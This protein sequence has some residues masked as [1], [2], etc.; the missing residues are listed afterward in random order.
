MSNTLTWNQ[1]PPKEELIQ[2]E[3]T[4]HSG[5]EV[6]TIFPEL[7]GMGGESQV[8]R[9]ERQSDH[10]SLAAK[11]TP[12]PAIPDA[13]RRK[14]H[15]EIIDTLMNG[16]AAAHHLMPVFAR[17]R[18]TLSGVR[19]EIQLLP[20]AE[21]LVPK[22]TEGKMPPKCDY[23]TLR[24]RVI[25]SL[26]DA[27]HFLHERRYVHR[28]IK[29][30]NIYRLG[31]R[32]VLGDFGTVTKINQ[33]NEITNVTVYVRGTPGFMAP[34]LYA[35][36]FDEA[37]DYYALGATIGALYTGKKHVYKGADAGTIN[38]L[39]KKKGIPL[40]C[41]PE[42]ED[43]Q[44]LVDWLIT[45]DAD[46]RA[47]YSEVTD[48]LNDR[49]RFL[50]RYNVRF[51]KN[52]GFTFKYKG[53]TYTSEAELTDTFIR[54]W[55]NAK[56]NIITGKTFAT[57]IQKSQ[58]PGYEIIDE[59]VGAKPGTYDSQEQSDF[60]FAR[61]LHYFNSIGGV[62]PP[63][64]WRNVKYRSFSEIAGDLKA[65]VHREEIAQMLRAGFL[66][67]KLSV[68]G[69]DA[70]QALGKLIGQTESRI[71]EN[72]P[73]A[74]F[75]LSVAAEEGFT[76][77][78]DNTDSAIAKILADRKALTDLCR[79]R[80]DAQK[81]DEA[82]EHAYRSVYEPLIR[83]GYIEGVFLI[84]KELTGANH[85]PVSRI[86]YLYRILEEYAGDKKAVRRHWLEN[87]PYSPTYY[88]CARID[89]Y[90][91]AGINTKQ[92]EISLKTKIKE[93]SAQIDRL[94]T[95]LSEKTDSAGNKP[96]SNTSSFPQLSIQPF[97]FSRIYGNDWNVER[98]RF[99]TE[100]LLKEK[101]N[102]ESTLAFLKKKERACQLKRDIASHT[103]PAAN[104]P[105][106][107]E[108]EKMLYAASRLCNEFLPMLCENLYH[109][110]QGKQGDKIVYTSDYTMLTAPAVSSNHIWANN[111]TA[112][113][114]FKRE[115]G[116]HFWDTAITRY[117]DSLL[118]ETDT[119]HPCCERWPNG[120]IGS[121]YSALNFFFYVYAGNSFYVEN[122]YHTVS[123]MYRFA[124][125]TME[126]IRSGG[127][128]L[129]KSLIGSDIGWELYR[130]YR[131]I[132]EGIVWGNHELDQ[133]FYGG[134][135]SCREWKRLGER[136]K[137]AYDAEYES[138]LRAP[139]ANYPVLINRRPD[140]YRP[141]WFRFKDEIREKADSICLCA[142][143]KEQYTKAAQAYSPGRASSD[144]N[145]VLESARRAQS[146]Y[147]T[148]RAGFEQYVSS[149]EDEFNT[150][151]SMAGS[152]APELDAYRNAYLENTRNRLSDD[153]TS[154]IRRWER[155]SWKK[156]LRSLAANRTDSCR[157]KL[158]AYQ[159]EFKKLNAAP[160]DKAYAG[161]VL[162]TKQYAEKT[163]E[164]FDD[165]CSSYLSEK[166]AEERELNRLKAEAP[167]T[168]A[169][170][171]EA[172]KSYIE[173]SKKAL[174]YDLA[175][176]IDFMQ[177]EYWE[178]QGLC[179]HC[180][181]ELKSGKGIKRCISC[182]TAYRY[183]LSDRVKA[184]NFYDH[185]LRR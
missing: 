3:I 113:I 36:Y 119:V 87:G 176:D 11:V 31:D 95:R 71:T 127:C 34:E 118:N 174:H 51:P 149:K 21:N 128:P 65:G 30:E 88:I 91:I 126:R 33:S 123:D 159:R 148:A 58:H 181:G 163:K 48:W 100:E 125:N 132:E 64:Y 134:F 140:D 17:E 111:Q 22:T 102:A 74:L 79:L 13:L 42:E 139:D 20:P 38:S 172:W 151:R 53:I 137:K 164:A 27:M 103:P 99:D 147:Q 124:I 160:A 26:L 60:Y 117:I 8:F 182:G 165:Y 62:E 59:Q 70:A 83:C 47:G 40:N 43:L 97:D 80:F 75:V 144:P 12:V 154:D 77:C 115:K 76:A 98:N 171:D 4:I 61:F 19:A 166:A 7:I 131:A 141:R 157:S 110:M 180:G 57:I 155:E 173:A 136:L 86:S 109:I 84:E 143:S 150:I 116:F 156:K 138:M 94:K 183:T 108:M 5:N 133:A 185:E 104:P 69:S 145:A 85:D 135:D 162:R 81:G 92:H 177:K 2:N 37:V 82:R 106:I 29:P 68:S 41:P 24:E 142:K 168:A 6:Y 10:M 56:T 179:N 153:F 146:D 184:E 72:E 39:T 93:T 16:D 130:I 52:N 112:V 49:K 44:Q 105:S 122:Q 161:L 114:G 101:K 35:Q 152:A 90:Q 175:S 23:K 63:V 73:L 158:D 32:I 45:A 54:D 167:E 121:D 55:D 178:S 169:E 120:Y 170:L 66:S 96:S 46:R 78:Q 1:N 50:S 14:E 28:D 18:T 89:R 107:T 25:P 9:A 129:G 67:W 15:D